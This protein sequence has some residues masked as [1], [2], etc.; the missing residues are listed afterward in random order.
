MAKVKDLVA[1]TDHT[2]E[3]ERPVAGLYIKMRVLKATIGTDNDTYT[4]AETKAA[5]VLT[6][7]N[8]QT[9]GMTYVDNTGVPVYLCNNMPLGKLAEHAQSEEGVIKV[10]HHDADED[11]IEMYIPL[12][13]NG[14]YIPFGDDQTLEIKLTTDASVTAGQVNTIE[15]PV[16]SP[17][18]Y[19]FNKLL[20]EENR[21]EKPFDVRGYE[22]VMIPL[23]YVTSDMVIT[24][25]H[26]NGK[27]IRMGKEELIAVGL[28]ANDAVTQIHGRSVGGFVG[29]AIVNVETVKQLEFQRS[30]TD[31]FEVIAVKNL[32]IDGLRDVVSNN[33]GLTS[34]V[35][36]AQAIEADKKM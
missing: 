14:G 8:G 4:T 22:S 11:H 28:T 1:S 36:V 21:D 33:K 19:Q 13:A 18:W 34:T 20:V 9:I 5:A 16:A 35:A 24:M 23:A 32:L 15:S 30:S 6:V 2:I 7:L 31:A 27:V 12:N 3:I 17:D 25:I 26:T 10:S 29:H